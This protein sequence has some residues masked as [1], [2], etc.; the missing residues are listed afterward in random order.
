M[1]FLIIMAFCV[2]SISIFAQK[3]ENC[4]LDNNPQLTNIES[5]FL[6]TYF[7]SNG[8][9][10]AFG[11]RQNINFD[12]SHKKILFVGKL[13][14]LERAMMEKLLANTKHVFMPEY[15]WFNGTILNKQLSVKSSRLRSKIHLVVVLNC[16]IK[17]DI[18]AEVYKA[19]I[20]TVVLSNY[21]NIFN[22]K[23]SYKILGN[24]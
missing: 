12:F 16:L 22:D 4:G 5:T 8:F 9:V 18:V 7:E 21:L 11:K 24:F 1:R 13:S 10:D 3:V 14:C 2:L 20:P 19:K 23:F 15:Q 17:S 6:N